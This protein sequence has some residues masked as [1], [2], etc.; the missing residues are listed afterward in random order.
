[1]KFR[2][3]ITL[4]LLL[5]IVLCGVAFAQEFVMPDANLQHAVRSALGLNFNQPITRVNMLQLERLVAKNQHI[6]NLTGLEHATRLEYLVLSGNDISDLTPLTNLVKLR[7]L[8]LGENQISDIRPLANL[9]NLREL[10]LS[11][12][13]VTDVLPLSTLT[14]LERLVLDRNLIEDFTPLTNLANIVNLGIIE[15]PAAD[16]SAILAMDI[17]YLSYD[18]CCDIEP[19]PVLNRINNRHYP[20]I[21][22]PW[23]GGPAWTKALNK[24]N[25]TPMERRALHDLWLAGSHFPLTVK[26]TDDG[27][28][29]VGE[30]S[31]ARQERDKYLMINPNMVFIKEVR[32][33]SLGLDQLP[34]DSPFWVRDANGNIANR[35]RG[36]GLY[37]FTNPVVLAKIIDEVRAVARC[38]LYDGVFFDHWNDGDTA[39]AGYRPL[40]AE[41]QA[42]AALMR[43]I[44]TEL[45][46]DFLVLVNGGAKLVGPMTGPLV[47][48]TFIET[49]ADFHDLPGSMASKFRRYAAVLTW[50]ESTMQ[51]PLINLFE[52]AVTLSAAPDSP[53][54]KRWMRVFTTISL[55][56][57]D[58]YTVFTNGFSHDHHWYDFWD[59]D[60]GRSVGEKGQLYQETEGLYIREFTNG[61]AA[62]N[63]SGADHTIR[64]PEDAVGVASG[65][66]EMEHTLPDLDGEMYLKA[67]VS[68]QSPVTSKNPAD[69]NGDGVVNILDL[70][71]V[72]QAFGKDGLQ[73]DVNG[74]GVVNVFDLVF[75]ANQF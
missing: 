60:L 52:G 24:P 3:K 40:E 12:N 69:V 31:K 20:S 4:S 44:R 16:Y 6:V 10:H 53:I 33:R 62:Y 48:G 49:G 13:M 27:I 74:D 66:E 26:N 45:R 17:P 15:N 64:L 75:V 1:M 5:T 46:P 57:S 63:N 61:W 21:A 55:T 51:T 38:G 41:Q 68:D 42:R 29:I 2:H 25:L 43:F 34:P 19:L 23:G 56:H 7:H 50:S 36:R 59:A 14:N 32:V 35:D 70:T 65:L 22:S 9:I 28:K 71:L 37:D 58:A 72:A 67:V 54:N 18:E 47:N 73:G 11:N 8:A 39:L 30:V